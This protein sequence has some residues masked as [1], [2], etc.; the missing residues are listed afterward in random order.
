LQN[1]RKKARRR[2]KQKTGYKNQCLNSRCRGRKRVDSRDVPS[3]KENGWSEIRDG[4]KGGAPRSTLIEPTVR[5]GKKWNASSDERREIRNKRRLEEGP[6]TRGS[7][8][9]RARSGLLNQES[10]SIS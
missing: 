6:G 5:T 4:G 10:M 1:H 8:L 2:Q 3:K 9:Q 7:L